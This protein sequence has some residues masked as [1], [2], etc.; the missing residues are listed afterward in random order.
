MEISY[1]YKFRLYPNKAQQILLGKHFG[2]IRFI[3]NYFLNQ[4]VDA[5]LNHKKTLNY[6]DNARD[7]TIIKKNDD[8]SWLK[9]VNA[10]SLQFALKC[11][12][13]AY[14]KFFTKSAKFPKFKNRK[15]K[16][17]FCVPQRGKVKDGR[18]Y[19]AKFREGIKIQVQRPI[20][21]EI[22]HI[23]VSRNT[24]G[25][26]FACIC[27]KREIKPL[28]PKTKVVGVDLGIKTLAT[29]SDGKTYSNIKPYRTLEIRLRKL[30]QWFARTTKGTGLHE[31]IR[32]RIAK[33]HQRITN[34]RNDHLHKVSWQMI[35]DNGT[36]VLEDLNI[37]GMM[38]NHCLAKSVADVSLAELVRM[39]KYKA[40]WYGRDV[41][42]VDRWFP[43]SKTC[44]ACS[45]IKQDLTLSDREWACPRCGVRHDRDLNA[46][47]NI[48]KQGLALQTVGITGMAWGVEVRPQGDE[49]LLKRHSAMKHETLTK[50]L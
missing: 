25:Q 6:Y 8:K 37:K 20:E 22:K 43:S 34:I 9:E 26:Y 1:T 47:K 18:M 39:V 12:E 3:Y 40:A 7:L 41:I 19:I 29:L 28:P 5:Y 49:N 10:Q 23:T 42:Q 35:R 48:K 27:V 45:Y 11:L 50:K 24:S 21:G 15:S 13:N 30:Q 31:K 38:K 32:K 46:A 17:S 4:R 33:L 16:Q 36:I 14:G 44:N 2:C